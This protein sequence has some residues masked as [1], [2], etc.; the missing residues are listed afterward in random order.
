[1]SKIY[2]HVRNSKYRFSKKNFNSSKNTFYLLFGTTIV[3]YIFGYKIGGDYITHI[4]K[5]P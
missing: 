1:M 4:I 2:Q 5:K 3:S